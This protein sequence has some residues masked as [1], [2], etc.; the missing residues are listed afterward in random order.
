MTRLLII[1]VIGALPGTLCTATSGLE[2]PVGITIS[3][4]SKKSAT[5]PAAKTRTDRLHRQWLPK[6]PAQ[7]S[8]ADRLQLGWNPHRV[9]YCCLPSSPRLARIDV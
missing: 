7:L 3:A 2:A 6:D 8:S 9:R 1:V 5:R 4:A